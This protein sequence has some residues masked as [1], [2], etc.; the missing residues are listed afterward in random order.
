[1]SN[2]QRESQNAAWQAAHQWRARAANTSSNGLLGALKLTLV[3]LAFGA[4]MVVGLVF[5]LFFLLVG[6]ALMPFMRHKMKKR[7]EQMRADNAQDIGGGRGFTQGSH[8][9]EMDAIE[10][11]FEVKEKS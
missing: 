4:L 1:M 2:T 8:Q 5:G 3:W 9:R 10:G 6:W 7:M 11:S